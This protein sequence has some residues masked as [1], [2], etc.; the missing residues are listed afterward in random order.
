MNAFAAN[1]Q[2]ASP[3]ADL[4]S[5]ANHR[6][7]NHLAIVASTIQ[8]QIRRIARGPDL[9]RREAASKGLHEAVGKI[10]AI[11]HLHRRLAKLEPKDSMDICALLIES[12]NEIVSA[13]SLS[14]RVHVRQKLHADCQVSADQ[15]SAL[16]LMMS[17]IVTNAIKYAHPTGV[18]IQID[19]ACVHASDGRVVLE[20]ADDG[21]GFP[22]G[23][24]E[25][26]DGGMG[27]KLI[28]ALAG[29]IGAGLSITSS[30][31]GLT[32]LLEIP[33]EKLSQVAAE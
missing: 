10:V 2:F 21:V 5:E 25:D 7:A 16:V 30:D 13:L 14:D 24:A 15:A 26:R 32:Y 31:L 9:L 20:I 12:V 29:R 28:R 18:P 4:L 11:A 22:E 8:D 23:F 6:I 17:E 3:S 1:D 19:I 27:L 33:A